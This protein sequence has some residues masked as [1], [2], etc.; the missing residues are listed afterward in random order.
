[1]PAERWT[2]LRCGTLL[3]VPGKSPLSP[4]TVVV[5]G[6][7]IAQVRPGLAVTDELGIPGDAEVEIVDLTS[8]FVLPGLIDSHT[9]I[10]GQYARGIRL[11]RLEGSDA[12]SAIRGV[13]YAERTLLAGFTTVRNVG[14]RGDAV[15]ALRDAIRAGQIPGPR[16]LVA[17]ESLTPTGGHSDHTL[18]YRDDLFPPPSSADGICDGVDACRRA[19]R[20]QVKRGADLIKLTATGGVLSAVAAGTEL[21]FFEDELRAIVETAHL[22]GRKVAAH[23]HGAG[24]IRAALLAGVDSIE[25][26]TFLDKEAIRLFREK[27]AFLVPTVLAGKTVEERAG[28]PGFFP[29]AVAEKARRVGPKIQ[30]ALGRAYRGG[31]RIAFGTDSGVSHHGENAREFG[32]MVEA[33]ITPAD[34]IAAATVNAAQ[35][36]GLSS[37]I[38]A[39]EAEKYADVIATTANPLEEIRALEA[40]RFVMRSGV[41][42]RKD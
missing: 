16:I 12:D 7:R 9:H 14:S 10:T 22:L 23:A 31:V 2:V 18:G 39:V 21:Q 29:P 34:A 11:K 19:V 35:L 24:G 37:E 28:E 26:G 4:A 15:F 38:G 1:M 33:G 17:G 30:S 36:L 27:E 41:V 3:A 13:V 42:Y 40:V 6:D 8:H 5:R 32:L 25:H 20:A